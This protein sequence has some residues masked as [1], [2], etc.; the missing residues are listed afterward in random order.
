M[1]K[2]ITISHSKILLEE[3]EFAGDTAVLFLPGISGGAVGERF[4][5]LAEMICAAHLTSVRMHAW[6][7]ESD[8]CTK[9]LRELYEEIETVVAWLL[10]NGFEQIVMIGKS[11]G[12]GLVLAYEHPQVV[13]KIL[14][15]PAI[16]IGDEETISTQRDT[17]LGTITD[18]LDIHMSL[19]EVREDD[20]QIC[21]IHG[22]MDTVIPLENSK[23]I[24]QATEN[25]ELRIV[26]GADHSFK[27]PEHEAELLQITKELLGAEHRP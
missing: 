4:V 27:R 13:Q 3:G 15:A 5:P 17:P 2:E 26:K 23:K 21:I 11:F 18:L 1:K 24:I 12:G 6:E 7:G 25:G 20:A 16:G 10:H 9:T 22:D 14:W 8:V 19:E